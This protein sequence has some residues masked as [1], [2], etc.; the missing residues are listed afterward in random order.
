[1]LEFESFFR[2]RIEKLDGG[3]RVM[4]QALEQLTLCSARKQAQTP[5]VIAFLKRQ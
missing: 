4:D 5:G 2:P 1:M 3:P